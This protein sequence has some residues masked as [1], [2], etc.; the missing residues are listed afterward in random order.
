MNRK[1]LSIPALIF[2]LL[3]ILGL[4]AA[5]GPD[6][7]SV[8]P[9]PISSPTAPTVSPTVAPPTAPPTT[10]PTN[11]PPAPTETVPVPPAT[12]TPNPAAG[13]GETQLPYIDDRSTAET[14]LISYVNAI[15]RREYVRAYSYW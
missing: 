13:G 11:T 4:L 5:C 9:T 3:A 14:L 12:P 10:A 1:S 7:S 8:T 2:S 15:E 6:T